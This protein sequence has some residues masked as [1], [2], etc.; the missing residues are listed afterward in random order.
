MLADPAAFALA[1]GARR[2]LTDTPT[3]LHLALTRSARVRLAPVAD[4]MGG[5][6]QLFIDPV[7]NVVTWLGTE[8]P[9]VPVGPGISAAEAARKVAAAL[10]SVR[11][12]VAIVAGDGNAALAATLAATRVGV[13][14]ARL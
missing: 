4:A 7:G 2:A 5:G 8:P 11:P 1:R 10:E 13:P 9:P 6:S 12:D 3:V 14:I